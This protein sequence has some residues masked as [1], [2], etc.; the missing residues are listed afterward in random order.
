MTEGYIKFNCEWNRCDIK[1]PAE[2]F[3]QLQRERFRLYELG[4]IGAYPDGIGFGNISVRNDDS[5]F[6]ITGSA[7]GQFAN[8]DIS[9]FAIVTGYDLKKNWLTCSGMTKASAESLTH[10]AVYEVV[11]EAKAVVH[12]HCLWL[13]EKMLNIYPATASEIEYGTPEM[14]YAIGKLASEL[15]DCDEK[16]IVMGGH[17]EGILAY[18]CNLHEATNQIIKTYNQY[19]K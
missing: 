1:I 19:L 6:T 17:R 15:K 13:W 8:L 4:L 10:A 16:I 5:T 18:G 2:K 11:S 9:H 3:Q 14:A 12:V 7:T